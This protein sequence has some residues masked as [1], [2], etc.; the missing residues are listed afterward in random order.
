MCF[1]SWSHCLLPWEKKITKG[2][3]NSDVGAFTYEKHRNVC[4][5]LLRKKG[6]SRHGSVACQRGKVGTYKF[7]KA[8]ASVL[9]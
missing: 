5:C 7:L 9:C 2:T 6:I 1:I 3:L 4:C 8:T